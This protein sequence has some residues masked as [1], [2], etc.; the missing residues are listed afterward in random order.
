MGFKERQYNIAQPIKAAR[1]LLRLGY[2]KAQTQRMLDKSRLHQQNTVVKKSDMLHTGTVNLVEF[3]PQDLGLL[4]LYIGMIDS[5][6]QMTIFRYNEN[7]KDYEI[8]VYSGESID[9]RYFGRY[10]KQLMQCVLRYTKNLDD[11]KYSTLC[12]SLTKNSILPNFYFCIFNKPAKLLTHPKN[13]DNTSSLLDQIRYDFGV[14]SNPCHRLDY[15][16]SGLVLCSLTKESE[17]CL[18]NLFLQKQIHKQYIAVVQGE[19]TQPM[20]IESYID[21]CRDFGNLCIKG[22]ASYIK[23]RN[24]KPQRLSKILEYCKYKS[25]NSHKAYTIIYPIQ[26]F[27]TLKQLQVF[28]ES[29]EGKS[30]FNSAIHQSTQDYSALQLQKS[31]DESL[32][33][34]KYCF[35]SHHCSVLG[36]YGFIQKDQMIWDITNLLSLRMHYMYTLDRYMKFIAKLDFSKVFE[37]LPSDSLHVATIPYYTLVKLIPIT[38]KTHQ[39]RLHTSSLHHAILGDTLYGINEDIASFFLDIQGTASQYNREILQKPIFFSFLLHNFLFLHKRYVSSIL[40]GIYCPCFSFIHTLQQQEIQDFF[41]FLYFYYALPM[42]QNSMREV[43]KIYYC[44]S[45]RLLLH[46]QRL[47]LYHTSFAYP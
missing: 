7:Y 47:M 36:F 44:K 43:M 26:T 41:S 34:H 40:S 24:I 2:T 21:F 23:T 14:E 17:V 37:T 11:L 20:L 8:I 30:I 27:H 5:Q 38:G 28:M 10:A 1:F 4:P 29:N 45:S 19:I 16:T 13:L 22:H 6:R 42:C 25:S 32:H 12:S 39:L 33:L 46:A 18:K 15:E 9:F 31:I 3:I 35:I